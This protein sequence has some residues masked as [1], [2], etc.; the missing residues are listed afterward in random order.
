MEFSPGLW[1][2]EKF[3]DVAIEIIKVSYQDEKQA[4]LKIWW[5]NRGW[6]GEPFRPFSTPDRLI[7]TD[8]TGWKK[9]DKLERMLD[10]V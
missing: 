4:K 1:T 3:M 10:K 2:H 6:V 9:L 8:F 5:W 7:I